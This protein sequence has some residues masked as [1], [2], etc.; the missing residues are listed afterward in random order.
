MRA[1]GVILLSMSMMAGAQSATAAVSVT[2]T[3]FGKLPDGKPAELYTLKDADLEV[4]LTNYGARIVA[5]DAKDRNGKMA[6]VTLGYN[7][8][9]GYTHEAQVH[10]KTYFG[11][12]VG[13]YG[14]RIR[15]G[16]FTLDGHQY[17]VPQ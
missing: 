11:A 4:K 10:G 14:N 9:E 16:K 1:T 12:V 8:V 7:S 13:R 17:Q 15:N 3:D 2:K 5:I 6:D